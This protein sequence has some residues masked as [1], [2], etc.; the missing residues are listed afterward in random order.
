MISQQCS[1]ISIKKKKDTVSEIQHDCIYFKSH[2]INNN[3]S[4]YSLILYV[5]IPSSSGRQASCIVSAFRSHVTENTF[6]EFRLCPQALGF[7]FVLFWWAC[8]F[9]RRHLFN[10]KEQDD[11]IVEICYTALRLEVQDS[12]VHLDIL[13]RGHIS[14]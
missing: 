5:W 14:C 9:F 12:A 6:P 3:I 7:L 10:N 1:P 13:S 4:I 2:N 11:Y 8:G